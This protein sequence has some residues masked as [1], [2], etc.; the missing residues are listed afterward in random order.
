[1][2]FW[3]QVSA[4]YT[5][6]PALTS[7]EVADQGD[8]KSLLQSLVGQ[9]KYDFNID[10]YNEKNKSQ[11]TVPEALRGE[12]PTMKQR[13][14]VLAMYADDFVT[15]ALLPVQQQDNLTYQYTRWIHKPILALPIA[16]QVC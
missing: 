16:E 5:G 6:Q 8:F 11:W 13:I 9:A 1:M 14:D 3:R 15:R 10:P 12:N 2:A 4:A 7:T